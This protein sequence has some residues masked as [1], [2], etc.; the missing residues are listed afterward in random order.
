VRSCKILGFFLV[1]GIFVGIFPACSTPE[2][3]KA[4]HFEKGMNYFQEEKYKEAVIEFK[5]VV[6]IDPKY[7][8]GH[9]QMALAYLKI[10]SL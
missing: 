2:E 3:N 6:Q 4:K 1:L 8:P 7:G 9:Y 10:G 5:N